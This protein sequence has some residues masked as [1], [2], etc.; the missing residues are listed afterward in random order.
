M[1][2]HHVRFIVALTRWVLTNNYVSL[3]EDIYLQISGT[4]MGTPCAVVFACIFVHVL[5][6]E[7]LDVLRSTTYV[8]RYIY[9]FVR[10]IDDL[11][12]IVS[13]YDVGMTLMK[14]LNSRRKSIKFTFRIRNSET[15]FLDLTL[16]KKGKHNQELAV[17]AFTK[18]M[19][20]FLFLPPNSCHPK[21]IFNGWIVGYGKRLRLNC[22]EDADFLSCLND[23]QSRL[24]A[25]GYSKESV[26]KA[27]ERIPSRQTI[28]DNLQQADICKQPK[29]I[30]TPFVVTYSPEINAI[31]PSIKRALS[32]TNEAYLDPHCIQI[33]GHRTTPLLS[34]KRGS[35]LRDVVAPSTLK[36]MPAPPTL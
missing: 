13:D 17:R 16:F 20:K 32:L 26:G 5:E 9:L 4:A 27:F 2:S 23:F 14:V 31:L 28:I 12:I 29:A 7:A 21:H 19:N 24:V 6:Q 25:R 11:S 34:F 3:G 10:F 1:C 33:F 18:P 15:Q 30:G 22:S 8:C 36:T 35:N